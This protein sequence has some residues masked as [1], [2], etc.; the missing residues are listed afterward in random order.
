M[1]LWASVDAFGLH[2]FVCKKAPGGPAR[3]HALNDLVAR[4]MASAGIPVSKEPQGL[5]CSDGKRPDCLS[6]IPWQSGKPLTWDV[7]DS[8]VATAL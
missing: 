3:H 6:L 4:V 1:P 7:T 5:S 2:G 8:Y